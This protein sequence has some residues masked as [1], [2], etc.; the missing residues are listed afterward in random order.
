[1]GD[2]LGIKI[3]PRVESLPFLSTREIAF[4]QE[5]KKSNIRT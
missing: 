5:A 2:R 3:L 4:I 1:M